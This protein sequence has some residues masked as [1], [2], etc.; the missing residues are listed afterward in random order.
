MIE[1][2]VS[3]PMLYIAV[4][5]VF[6]LIVGSFLNVVIYR[7]PIMLENAWKRE[8]QEY[9][10]L[11]MEEQAKFN[12]SVPRSHC[13]GCKTPVRDQ[14]NIP[15]LS[16]LFL[17]GKCHHCKMPIPM[18]YPLVELLTAAMVAVVAYFIP[19]SYWSFA[20]II[21]TFALIVLTMIDFQTMLLPDEITLPLMWA[22]LLLALFDVSPI[23]LKTA[24]LGAV[25]GYLFFWLLFWIFKILTGKEGMGY[26]DFKLTAAIGAWGGWQ[27]L[28]V[29]IFGAAILA[30]IFGIIFIFLK[31]KG[32]SI[33]F[34][35]GPYLALS[36]WIALMWGPLI[37][38]WYITRMIEH[39]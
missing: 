15:V 35:F 17:R 13:P 26:G 5:A 20:M 36:G 16:W 1:L 34:A 11:P 33:P 23:T 12:L 30:S 19:M 10:N 6:V 9:F 25:F 2:F 39:I 7:Y 18:K 32:K 4:A 28:P 22:G 29:T 31:N 21:A 8:Y 37:N 38:H 24:V 27:I 3:T 14:D